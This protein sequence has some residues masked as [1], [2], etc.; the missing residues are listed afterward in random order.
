MTVSQNVAYG[1]RFKSGRD[2]GRR[3]AEM[4]RVVQFAG[5][6]PLSGRALRGPAAAGRR[7]ARARGRAEVLLLD[8]P[9]SYLDANLCEEMRFEIR[10]LHE[11]FGNALR[12]TRQGRGNGDLGPRRRDQPGSRRADRSREDLFGRPRTR[13]VAEFIGRT[14]LL[15]TVTAAPGVAVRGALNGRLRPARELSGGRGRLSGP[16]VRNRRRAP[17]HRHAPEAC[18]LLA[19]A[20]DGG[21]PRAAG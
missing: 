10:R 19:E 15:D 20:G 3:V 17:R 4:L 5:Y 14:N 11:A 12:D 9:L 13:F 7:R 18:V 6:E 1:L 16:G 8:E 21:R 2:R